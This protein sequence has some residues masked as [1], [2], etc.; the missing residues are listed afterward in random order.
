MKLMR[1]DNLEP[2]QAEQRV[3]GAATPMWVATCSACGDCPFRSSRQSPSITGRRARRKK[4]FSPLTAVHV[5]NALVHQT[6]TTTG[7]TAPA[8]LDTAYL[9]DL[10]L[11][12]RAKVW[13]EG[14]Q[15][16]NPTQQQHEHEN[17]LCR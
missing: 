12:D 17:P 4:T 13:R 10:G 7:D 11:A 15:K 2:C 16:L 8:S 14:W 9:S 3:F 6:G 5:G 1:N